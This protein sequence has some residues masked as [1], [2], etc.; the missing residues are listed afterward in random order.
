[1]YIRRTIED[2]IRSMAE[3]FPCVA[4]YGPRQCGKSTTVD[5]LFGEDI[6]KVTLDNVEDRTLAINNPRLFIETYGWPL[7]I[8]EIQKAPELFDYIKIS[9]DEQNLK[10]VKNDQKREL[11]Y[12]ITGS[13]Q[14]ELQQSV[15]DSL[16][17]RCGIIDMSTF[18]AG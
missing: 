14:F 17:G 11:M 9:I 15:S 10:W 3:Q 18:F 5:F 13:S 12:I 8:D 1:M 16:A 2:T 4:I 7:V 6:R